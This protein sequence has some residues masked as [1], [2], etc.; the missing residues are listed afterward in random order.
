LIKSGYVLLYR[1]DPRR[2]EEGKN[3]LQLDSPKPDFSIAPLIVGENRF[4]SLID[5]YPSEAEK[6]H[7]QLIEDLK[8]RYEYYYKM[9]HGSA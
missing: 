9:A 8:Q 5:L 2:K 1:Y 7:P 3:P 6:K 4:A